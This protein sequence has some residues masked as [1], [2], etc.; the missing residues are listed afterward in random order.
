MEL[1][2]RD[3]ENGGGKGEKVVNARGD[4]GHE[5]WLEFKRQPSPL[6]APWRDKMNEEGGEEGGQSFFPWEYF[7]WYKG[8][9]LFPGFCNLVMKLLISNNL[10]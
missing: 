8:I 5:K 9:I 7:L 2:A 1:F 6:R 4:E 10:N 3:E